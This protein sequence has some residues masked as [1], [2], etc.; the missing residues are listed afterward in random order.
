MK[1]VKPRTLSIVTRCYESERKKYFSVG[2]LSLFSFDHRMASEVDMWKFFAAELG[3]EGVPDAGMVK[4]RGEFLVTGSAFTANAAPAATIDARVRIGQL[5]KSLRVS[6]ARVWQGNIA[7]KP[8]LITETPITWQNAFG[9]VNFARNPLGIGFEPVIDDEGNKVYPLPRI[10]NPDQLVLSTLDRPEPASF[11]PVDIAWPQRQKKAGTYDKKWLKELYPGLAKD[12]DMS[13]FN[14]ASDDQQQP[15]YFQSNEEFEI[16]GMHPTKS[17]LQGTLPGI[18]ARCFVSLVDNDQSLSEISMNLTTV[19]FFPKHERFLIVHHGSHRIKTSDGTDIGNLVVAAERT[20]APKSMDH[21]QHVLEKRLDKEQAAVQALKDSD[22]LPADI[23]LARDAAMSEMKE[24]ME[25][26]NLLQQNQRRGQEIQNKQKRDEI[27]AMGLN[28]DDYIPLLPPVEDEPELDPENV[29]EYVATMQAKIE[30]QK[31]E[32]EAQNAAKEQATRD[33]LEAQGLDPDEYMPTSQNVVGPPAFRAQ[34]EYQKALDS[35]APFA[36]TAQGAA[37]EGLLA[38]R[39]QQY[40]DSEEQRREGY[41]LMAHHQ[42]AVTRLAGEA[43]ENGRKQVE[44]AVSRGK[45]LARMDLTG[46]DLSDLDLSG[47]DLSGAWM[48]NVNLSNSNL[49]GADLSEAVLTRSDLSN[50]DVS[51]ANLTRSNVA[52]TLFSN[53]KVDGA[54]FHDSILSR[55]QL[56]TSSFKNAD[57][58]GANL[59]SLIVQSCDFTD[60]SLAELTLNEF[61]LRDVCFASADLSKSQFLKCNI[62]ESDFTSAKLD[63]VTFLSTN[64]AQADFTG[65]EMTNVRFVEDCSFQRAVFHKATLV[66]SNLRGT[67]LVESDFSHANLVGSDFSNADCTKGNFD[68]ADAKHCLFM[69]STCQGTTFRCTDLMNAILQEANVLGADLSTANLYQADLAN[70]YRDAKTSFEGANLKKARLVPERPHA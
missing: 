26:E 21:Y 60:A 20:D 18:N 31:R 63:G 15:E 3:N 41:R 1:V 34:E 2:L 51:G 49:S 13:F 14:V 50:A 32:I 46:F 61:E 27:A 48:E 54:K 36:G 19:W 30:E 53:T 23:K 22:L 40:F 16:H 38:E 37:M 5:D 42:G 24:L 68:R 7:T 59:E 64:G 67:N 25:T 17:T 47:C 4:S 9:G 45:H 62:S 52:L 33:D 39:R 11:G 35:I 56:K 58:S 43:C 8:A 70:I 29:D 6:S 10:E 12:I 69:H 44:E 66:R 57:F 28:P 55:A 65:A